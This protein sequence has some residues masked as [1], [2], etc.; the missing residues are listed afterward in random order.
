VEEGCLGQMLAAKLLQA[1]ISPKLKLC[2]LGKTF[3]QQ[4]AVQ[5]L[6]SACSIDAQSIAQTVKELFHE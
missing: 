4:G 5:Q 1:E 2:N 6:Y 3:V